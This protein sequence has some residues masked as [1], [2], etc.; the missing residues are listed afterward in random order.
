MIEPISV[1][2][3]HCE[4]NWNVPIAKSNNHILL[5]VTEGSLQYTIEDKTFHLHKG[6]ILFVPQGVVRSASNSTKEGHD[7]YVAHFRYSGEGE[8]LP[9][10]SDLLF[11]YAHPFN[12]DYL[13][14]RFSL[15]S[16]HWLRKSAY[17]NTICHSMLLE[18]LAI[19]NE[20]SDS[21]FFPSKQYG[22]VMQLQNYILEHYHVTI[23]VS[24]LS[25]FV[26]RTPNYVSMVFKQATGQTITE[27]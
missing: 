11:R 17:M 5:L 2:F 1:Y 25:A 15:L 14:Q 8:H 20:E 18:I 13:K 6:D 9:L 4:P 23:H 16:Q 12:F 21:P 3:E 22:L 24:E 26:E 7:M 19:T 27:Y 10:L